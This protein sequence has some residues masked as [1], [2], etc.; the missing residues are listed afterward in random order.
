MT[1]ALEPAEEFYGTVLGW[2]FQPGS[3]GEEFVVGYHDGVPVAG[4][5]AVARSYGVPV[6]WTPYFAVP[7]MDAAAAR[8]RERAATVAVGPLQ[9][10]EG[11]V[12]LAADPHG[13]RFGMWQGTVLPSWH[14][15][16]REPPARLDLRTRDAF[17]A[18]I[19]YAQVLGW[20]DSGDADSC[21]VQ[22]AEDTV[23]VLAGGHVAATL[24]GGAVEAAPDPRVRP[25]WEVAF[26]VDDLEAAAEAAL[27][28]GGSLSAENGTG[29]GPAVTL[30]DPDGALFTLRPRGR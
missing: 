8:V 19:F 30:A 2:R 11:R 5:G 20:T 17:A 9:L 21:D 25:H 6:G 18:A 16:R 22:Y 15:G 27:A 26:Y 29:P 7:D 24:Y 3:L 1:G 23:A 28:A 13:G 10:G 14:A 4:I 12:A